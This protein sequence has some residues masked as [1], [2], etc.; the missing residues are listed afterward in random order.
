LNSAAHDRPSSVLEERVAAL[1]GGRAGSPSRRATLRKLIAFHPLMNP[2]DEF[3]AARQLYGGSITQFKHS[4]AKFDWHVKFADCQKP[5]TFKAAIGRRRRR[6]ISKASPI[7]AAS[8]RYR[9]DRENR[10]RRRRAADCRQ[11]DGDALSDPSFEWGAD[12]IVHSA[13]KF[14]GV[15]ATHGRH[16]RRRRQVQLGRGKYPAL[17]EPCPSYHGM[18]MWRRSATWPMPSPAA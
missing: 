6:S 9:S 18:K 14:L 16:R 3:V 15:T 10:A 8:S 12:I 13:T 1:E 5:D 4:F 17:S 2:G 7:P 11:H